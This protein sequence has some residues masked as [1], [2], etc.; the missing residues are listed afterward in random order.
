[1]IEELKINTDS[2][3][4]QFI[5]DG[6]TFDAVPTEV[7]E[8]DTHLT[9]E[10]LEKYS[11]GRWFLETGTYRG[12]TVKLALA[13]GLFDDIFS[14]ELNQEMYDAVVP[15]FENK[16]CVHIILGE[17]PD[18]IQKIMNYS[19]PTDTVTFWL[20]AHASGPLP[21]GKYGGSPLVEELEAIL[22]SKNP[23]HTIFID[24]RRLFGS[25]E[26][27]GLEEERVMEILKQINPNY[28]IVYL[29]GQVPEDIICA[30][31]R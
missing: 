8:F 31:T 4:A 15:L 19:V 27:D 17:S 11:N 23:N 28:N 29:D 1:M 3:D 18:E 2:G 10:Y 20:D 30:H 24:D 7:P 16:R 6:G 9:R 5:F 22:S 12:E 14:V 26:W 25:Q 13:T 21:G